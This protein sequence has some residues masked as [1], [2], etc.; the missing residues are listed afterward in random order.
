MNIVQYLAR[1][2]FGI[3]VCT[4]EKG[5]TMLNRAFYRPSRMKSKN[6]RHLRAENADIVDETGKK[7]PNVHFAAG[8]FAN[9]GQLVAS[10]VGLEN[11]RGRLDVCPKKMISPI[12]SKPPPLTTSPANHPA[13]KPP[14]IREM[15]LI[16]F[17]FY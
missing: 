4:A 6:Y 10:S 17:F 16:A 8:Y 13:I 11:S 7:E 15:L 2:R 9:Q 14:T 5:P 12:M 1:R 3:T